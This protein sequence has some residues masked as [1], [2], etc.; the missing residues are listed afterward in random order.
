MSS[1]TQLFSSISDLT[2]SL[3]SLSNLTDSH[4][5]VTL[6]PYHFGCSFGH[7]FKPYKILLPSAVTGSVHSAHVRTQYDVLTIDL[8]KDNSFMPTHV[9]WVCSNVGNIPSCIFF[10]KHTCSPNQNERAVCK[11]QSLMYALVCT[12][13]SGSGKICSKLILLTSFLPSVVELRSVGKSF[14][15]DPLS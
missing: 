6:A 10:R 14:L 3:I 8:Y 1:L 5:A 7:F 13:Y 9:L 4:R 12:W 2:D 11:R 15:G